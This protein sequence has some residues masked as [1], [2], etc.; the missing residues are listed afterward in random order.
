MFDS[1]S[2][3]LRAFDPLDPEEKRLGRIRGNPER[4]DVKGTLRTGF[5]TSINGSI[6]IRGDVSVGRYGAIG[7][8]FRAFAKSH[9]TQ[10][11]NMLIRI[12]IEIGSKLGVSSRGPIEV[13]HSV[14][15]GDCVSILSGVKVG[16]GAIL[17]VGSVITKDV[18]PFSIVGGNPAKH[19]RYRFTKAVRKQLLELAWWDWDVDR[20]ARNRHLFD[21]RIG[22]R[23]NLKLK[24]LE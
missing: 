1:E 5:Y 14:W 2:N 15:I 9:D 13:G 11:V 12:Q 22:P 24:I 19:I 4:W 8:E 16:H 6:K 18:E 10:T 7:D 21:Q 20:I 3:T 17:G 23:E